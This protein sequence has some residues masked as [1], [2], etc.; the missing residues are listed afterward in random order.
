MLKFLD[1]I[2]TGIDRFAMLAVRKPV[3]KLFCLHK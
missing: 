1:V 3:Q 2:I